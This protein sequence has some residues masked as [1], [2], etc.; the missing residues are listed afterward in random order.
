VRGAVGLGGGAVAVSGRKDPR[1]REKP[2]AE[3][4]G[5]NHKVQIATPFEPP[6][7]AIATSSRPGGARGGPQSTELH[8]RDDQDLP[9]RFPPMRGT[10]P[11]VRISAS[12]CGRMRFSLVWSRDGSRDFDTVV[13]GD[14][15]AAICTHRL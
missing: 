14:P 1:R 6:G 7:P 8:T 5:E 15:A 10:T 13:G 11:V 3:S 9:R 4:L 2:R 12:A